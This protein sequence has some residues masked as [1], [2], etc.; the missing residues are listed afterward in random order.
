MGAAA[1]RRGN[2]RHGW[3]GFPREMAAFSQTHQCEW[4]ER[5]ERLEREN[6]TLKER[7]GCIESQ[8]ALLQRTVF[9]K[10]S[11]KLPR[12]EDELR[13][14]AG[15]PPRPREATLKERRLKRE[16]R[17]T[18]PER[19]IHHRIPDEAR[20]CPSC[21]GTALKPLAAGSPLQPPPLTLPEATHVL[22][23]TT[24]TRG[25]HAAR[26]EGSSRRTS[27]VG[28]L[29][30]AQSCA[31]PAVTTAARILTPVSSPYRRRA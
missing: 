31:S 16:A 14:A 17:P 18:L 5:A 7:V 3:D 1:S 26:A 30:T 28:R 19:V 2:A 15:G 10:K 23:T 21:G 8:L 4:R 29:R 25:C 12:V 13:E 20:R 27:P 22:A 6:L 9:G 24:S 11:E